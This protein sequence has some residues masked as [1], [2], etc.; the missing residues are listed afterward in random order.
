MGK[1]IK[2]YG[3]NTAN[4]ARKQR[5]NNKK[6]Q[7]KCPTGNINERQDHRQKM[8]SFPLLPSNHSHSAHFGFKKLLL[9][10]YKSIMSWVVVLM[11]GAVYKYLECL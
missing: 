7:F 1:Y 6:L 4:R 3:Y 5:T 10:V 2:P 9:L 11:E 8:C